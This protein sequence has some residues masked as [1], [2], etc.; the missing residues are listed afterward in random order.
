MQDKI[1]ASEQNGTIKGRK[2]R[3]RDGTARGI[4]GI[5]K[6]PCLT[7][8]RAPP[9]YFEPDEMLAEGEDRLFGTYVLWSETRRGV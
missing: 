8:V 7:A 6:L 3:E 2:R 4:E 9:T 5:L 1:G